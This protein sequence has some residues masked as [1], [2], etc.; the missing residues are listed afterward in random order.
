MLLPK[1]CN[2]NEGSVFFDRVVIAVDDYWVTHTPCGGKYLG[3]IYSTF[4]DFR[5]SLGLAYYC[6]VAASKSLDLAAC[7]LRQLKLQPGW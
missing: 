7:S 3:D 2:K 4:D 6:H 1:S 5:N